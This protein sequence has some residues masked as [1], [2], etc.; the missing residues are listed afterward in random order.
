MRA[1]AFP[2]RSPTPTL[3]GIALRIGPAWSTI[4][5]ALVGTANLKRDRKFSK[6]S[7]WYLIFDMSGH[8]LFYC[9]PKMGGFLLKLVY[10]DRGVQA[11]EEAGLV[12]DRL[13][14]AKKYAEGTLLEFTEEELTP[15]LLAQLLRVKA[16]S[17]T[18]QPGAKPRKPVPP[19]HPHR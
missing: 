18:R 5:E 11:L 9:F 4:S 13:R 16:G 3:N 15:A 19:E 12:R 14:A 8:R 7:G 2:E 17:M 1:P 10:N 6:T